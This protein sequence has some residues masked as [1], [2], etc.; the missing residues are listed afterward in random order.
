MHP[1]NRGRVQKELST[2]EETVDRD[3]AEVVKHLT[4]RGLFARNILEPKILQLCAV[5]GLTVLNALPQ[6]KSHIKMAFKSGA[7]DAEVKEAIIQMLVYCGLPYIIQAFD[8][9]KEV[10]REQ[11][12]GIKNTPCRYVLAPLK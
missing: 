1:N 8:V 3:F 9:Y 10:V 5:S 7:T 4:N 12:S 11:K 2:W 6:L